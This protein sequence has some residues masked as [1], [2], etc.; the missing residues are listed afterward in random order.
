VE[1]QAEVGPGDRMPASGKDVAR[2]QLQRQDTW[3]RRAAFT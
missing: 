2:P 3:V 1:Q